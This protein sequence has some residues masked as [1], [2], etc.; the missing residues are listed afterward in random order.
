[1]STVQT[2]LMSF[3]DFEKL[4]DP[5]SGHLELH[6]GHVTHIPPRRL[7]HAVIQQTLS[8]LLQPAARGKGFLTIEFPFRPEP[9]YEAWQADVAFVRKDRLERSAG[10][11]YF[12]G[13]ADLVIEVLSASNTMDEIN[14]RMA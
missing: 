5:P 3:E 2:G 4:P 7:S 9:E 8:D 10:A 13:A 1:M 12:M 6:H 14:D 11:D